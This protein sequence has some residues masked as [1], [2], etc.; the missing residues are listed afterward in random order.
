M[1]EIAR[2]HT[3]PKLEANGF[4][5]YKGRSYAEEDLPE[6]V[7]HQRGNGWRAIG[8]HYI[9]LGNGEVCEGRKIHDIGAHARGE[10]PQSIGVCVVGDN[11]RPEHE[12]NE[13]QVE[14]L[15]RLCGAFKLLFPRGKVMGHSDVGETLCPGIDVK[16]IFDA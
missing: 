2:W 14:A 10:N 1:G 7:R 4:F 16:E 8:Y 9:I 6:A 13:V 5:T 15:I 11:T 3:G 12:W